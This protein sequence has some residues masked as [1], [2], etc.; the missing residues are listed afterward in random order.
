M[1]KSVLTI[2]ILIF[3][4]SGGILLAQTPPVL[5]LPINGALE[6]EP[7]N[8]TLAWDIPEGYQIDS[9]FDVFCDTDPSFPNPAVYSGPLTPSRTYFEWHIAATLDQ[10]AYYWF[11]RYSY[12][13]D[14]VLQHLDS[15]VNTFTTAISS[16]PKSKISGTIIPGSPF[17]NP[18]GV[19]ITCPGACIPSTYYTTFSGTY[20]FWVYNGGNYTVTPALAGF[21]FNPLFRSYTNIQN[22][23]TGQNFIMISLR[24]NLAT[25]P[26]PGTGSVHVPITTANLQWTYIQLAGYSPPSGFNVYFPADTALPV[27][28]PYARDSLFTIEIGPLNYSTYYD[29]KVVPFNLEGEAEGVETW[30]FYTEDNPFLPSTLYVYP[31]DGGGGAPDAGLVMVW[32]TEGGRDGD[33]PADSFFDVYLDTDSLFPG[34]P[35]YSGPGWV[36]SAHPSWK[37]CVTP[38]LQLNT[39]YYWRILVTIPSLEYSGFTDTWEFTTADTHIEHPAPV[40]ISPPEGTLGIPPGD[41]T[42]VWDQPEIVPDSFFDVFVSLTPIYPNAPDPAT[43]VYSGPGIPQRTYFE[44]HFAA[45][46]D[47]QPYYWFVRYSNW[48][49]YWLSKSPVSYFITGTHFVPVELSSFSATYTA[50][51]FVSIKWTVQSETNLLGY[52]VLRNDLEELDT[53]QQLNTTPISE[54]TQSGTQ[55]SYLYRDQQIES[56]KTYYYWLQSLDLDGVTQMFGPISV[57][58]GD[59]DDNEVT[60]EVPV[61]T[62]LLNAYPN[63]FNPMTTIPYYLKTEGDVRIEIFNQKGQSVWTHFA[64]SQT[65]GFHLLRWDGRDLNG[66]LQTSGVYYYRM[67]SGKYSGVKKLILLK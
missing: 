23:Q 27:F 30:D 66:I 44:W 42:L 41:V 61:R 37:Y 13:V 54:G 26:I 65:A 25:Q 9:F 35:I 3:L 15:A 38:D 21:Y 2:L 18:A 45:T 63:P 22:D 58:I 28:V 7:L 4:C 10:Q 48:V 11:V 33:Y 51:Q 50:G 53:A 60:P 29:W 17:F 6:V 8:V 52:F 32:K 39:L 36:N 16:I 47:E 19:W 46:L 59:E 14:N 43:L 67:T 34:P 49:D 57:V 40:P 56:N 55:I 12:Y 62:T 5:L 1:K 31:S 20:Y 24:P 64:Q